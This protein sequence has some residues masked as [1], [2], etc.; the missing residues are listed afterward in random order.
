ML[1]CSASFCV[2]K[3][4]LE[5]PHPNFEAIKNMAFSMLRIDLSNPTLRERQLLD[6]CVLCALCAMFCIYNKACYTFG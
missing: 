2:A 4:L 1:T 5:I 3:T 6:L